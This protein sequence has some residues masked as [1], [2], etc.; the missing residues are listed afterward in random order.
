M[1]LYNNTKK[2][3]EKGNPIV[4]MYQAEIGITLSNSN[5]DPGPKLVVID[6]QHRLF[7]LQHTA[8]S[9]R[10][11]VEN[12]HI[13]VLIVYSPDSTEENE[14]S[15]LDVPEVFRRLFVDV[16]TQALT[17]SGHFVNTVIGYTFRSHDLSI[18]LFKSS[19]R[20]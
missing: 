13:P 6:G 9:H 17:V 12:I 2:Q 19:P 5:T 3:G 14:S 1:P 11:E 4:E 18:F 8:K 15:T 20:I 16:N 7:A 10:D